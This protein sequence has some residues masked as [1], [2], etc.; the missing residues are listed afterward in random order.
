MVNRDSLLVIARSPESLQDDEAISQ[1][2]SLPQERK[3]RLLHSVRN[4]VVH[5]IF[6]QWQK[7]RSL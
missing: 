2:W 3:P 7:R 6:T 1:L 5:W 4:D